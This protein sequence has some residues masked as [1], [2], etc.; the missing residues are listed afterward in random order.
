MKRSINATCEDDCT[1]KTKQ[2]AIKAPK[3]NIWAG[4]SDVE[5]AAVTGFLFADKTL[6]LTKGENATDWDNALYVIFINS[7]AS[8]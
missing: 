6:N 1:V 5:A 2:N 7:S 4:L 8:D 3:E